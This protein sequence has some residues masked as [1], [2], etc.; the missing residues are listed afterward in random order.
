MRHL[1]QDNLSFNSPVGKNELRRA[2][3][4]PFGHSSV[5]R[6]CRLQTI[7]G[8]NRIS[9]SDAPSTEILRSHLIR[10]R[11]KLVGCVAFRR[12]WEQIEYLVTTHQAPKYY[13]RSH[14]ISFPIENRQSQMVYRK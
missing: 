11:K 2:A 4:D 10:S 6:V 12:Y 14:L 9:G 3:T 7:F 8:A 13:D 1:F 5:G